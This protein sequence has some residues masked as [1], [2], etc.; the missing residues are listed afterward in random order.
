[1]HNFVELSAVVNE[2]MSYYSNRETD[3]RNNFIT[4]LKTILSSLLTGVPVFSSN[5]KS[6]G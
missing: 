3:R 6:H 5:V 4:M 1:V 2:L